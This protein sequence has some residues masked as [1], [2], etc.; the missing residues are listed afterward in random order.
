MPAYY[1]LAKEEVLK[2]LNTSLHGLNSDAIIPLQE[3]YGFNIIE[4]TKRKTR[5]SIL[6]SQFKD[7]MILILIIAAIISFFVGEHTDALVIIAIIT[8]NAWMGYSQEYD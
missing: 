8:A 7:V 4:E 5:L 2:Q 1:Q 6:A 3:R